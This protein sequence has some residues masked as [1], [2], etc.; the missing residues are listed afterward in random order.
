MKTTHL[1]LA[2]LFVSCLARVSAD[3]DI[4]S[5]DGKVLAFR[6]SYINAKIVG[7][8]SQVLVEEGQA[9]ERGDVLLR[10]DDSVEAANCELARIQAAD[11]TALQAAQASRDKAGKDLERTRGLVEKGTTPETEL[12]TAEYYHKLARIQVD[13]A[14]NDLNRLSKL[15]DYRQAVLDQYTVR[16]PFSGIIAAKLIELGESSHPTDKRLFLLID[17]SKVYVEVHP[18]ISLLTRIAVGQ[19]VAV[20]TELYPEKTF[21]GTVSFI[22][23]SNDPASPTFGFKVLVD[24]PESLLRPGLKASVSLKSPPEAAPEESVQ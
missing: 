1:L 5:L 23:P 7:N 10:L 22:S 17:I 6:S 18:D 19:G 14:Q 13:S 20:T 12:E 3:D 16:A 24:N 2:V 21:P 11:T 9:V 8:V 4:Q 15:V